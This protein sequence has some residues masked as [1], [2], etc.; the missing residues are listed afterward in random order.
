[1]TQHFEVAS[2]GPRYSRGGEEEE[3]RSSGGK[4]LWAAL[5]LA[6]VLF[7]LSHSPASAQEGI[8]EEGD[9]GV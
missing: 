3:V 4:Q 1:M 6:G 7:I 5:V 8:R 9:F 2:E